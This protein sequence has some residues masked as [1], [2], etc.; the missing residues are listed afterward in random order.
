MSANYQ[1]LTIPIDEIK[2]LT[3]QY[4][5]IKIQKIK[6]L[7]GEVDFN[8]YIKTDQSEEFAL[9][10]SRPDTDTKELDFQAAILN[11]LSKKAIP[12]D[13]PTAV[14]TIEGDFY[15][16]IDAK[17][18]QNRFIRLQKW[19]DGRVVDSINPRTD[20]V[21]QNWGKAIGQL[22]THLQGFDHEA[23]HRFYKW[24][25]C[26][27]LYSRQYSKHFQSQEQTETANYYWSYFEK[28]T[29]P[30]L[31]SLRKSVNYGDGH[32]L[33]LIANRDLKKPQITGVIDFGDAL[34]MPTICDLAIA[35]AYAGMGFEQPLTAMKEVVKGYHS[36]FPIT[37]KEL[38]VLFSLITARLMITVASAAHNKFKEPDNEYLQVSER[39]AWDVLQKLKPIHPNLA[40]YTFRAACGF[41]P[42]PKAA[43]FK[44]WVTE[45]SINFASVVDFHNKK[46]EILDL[47]VGS[48]DLG[49]NHDF[50]DQKRFARSFQRLM[51][52]KEIE[53]GVGGYGEIRPFYTTDAYQV[54]G[55]HGLQWRT[56]HLGLDIWDIAET[57]IFAPL[58]GVIH[59]FKNNNQDRDYGGT[60]IL[61]HE[62]SEDFTFY[63]LY[64]H[65][66][67]AS[68]E[69]LQVGQAIAKGEQMATFGIPDE[70]GGWPPHLHFQVMLDMFD[71]VGDFAG[72]AYPSEQDIW[73]SC[74]PN[75]AL[76]ISSATIKS[77]FKEK[78]KDATTEITAG[79]IL[80]TRQKHL[81]R[82]LSLSYQNPL[83]IVR[84]Y[85]QYLYDT[86]GRRYLDTV[87]NVAHVGHEHR[88]V[89]R[90]AQR[91]TA[92]LNT[93]TRYLHENI[94]R[95]AEQLTAMLPP[96]LSV[97]HF[98]NSGS[99]AN[100]LALRMAAAYTKQQDMLA[101]EVGYHGN[102]NRVIEVSSYKFDG[103]G[104]QGAPA[105]TH[106]MPMPDI[107]RGKH[108]NPQT[109]G[110]EYAAYLAAKIAKLNAEGKGIAGFI[111]E[112]ILSCGGQIVLPE[113]YLKAAFESVRAAGGVCI[114]DEVQVGFGRVGSHFWAFELQDVVPDIVTM[115]KPIGNG[116]PLGAVVCTPEVAAAFANGM[117]YFNTF[118]GN[119]VSCA[120]GS[121]VLNVV[122]N[123]GLQA[124]ALEVGEY[125]KNGLND[126]KNR[127]SVIGDVRGHGFFLGF[128]LVKNRK[129]LEPAPEQTTYLA[130]RMRALGFL[131]S[132][133]G[134][135]HNVIKI[136]PPMCF[137]LENADLL[138]R[139]LE[140]VLS[141]D[142]MRV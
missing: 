91:Q 5:G 68:L 58:D 31:S 72:V 116:H 132:T 18:G 21:L 131:M 36:V 107:Y 110:K 34:Y 42:H 83:H 88:Q 43:F 138:L 10:I 23:A 30:K 137:N 45:Q 57:P 84:G 109:A 6:P 63:T 24:N 119:P 117:E 128:E 61:A 94:T 14:P 26:E 67:I 39:P 133:D 44:K 130:N 108:R 12:L 46:I 3:N 60:I 49:N 97:V 9:K 66:S 41:V 136:K 19:V 127:F 96:E 113:G 55:N 102:T 89:I 38:E 70:N 32:E 75:P 134:L 118:G 71:N 139:F 7:Q 13:L 98:V 74:C 56:V 100:E 90:A 81:G 122:K 79:N 112:S 105:T 76:L 93:N 111:C 65:L 104:G 82:S 101:I 77:I 99:E 1:N 126:L 16:K 121:E 142:F 2:Q 59:S 103:K 54:I 106:V 120:I 73:L 17:Y 35:C 25:P 62:V 64:G 27:T 86:T 50:D 4:F 78:K 141:E 115:G 11:F 29:L 48:L 15:K 8:F 52:D 124:N 20:E 129:T 135:H 47:S 87:N 92:V 53:I 51:E 80:K 114:V 125:L 95:F 22:S 140:K 33:N 40:H 28:N 85:G 123:E 69:G 37:E